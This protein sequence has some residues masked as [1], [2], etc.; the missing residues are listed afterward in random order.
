M[1]VFEKPI[2]EIVKDLL[3]F[4]RICKKEIKLWQEAQ[5]DNE[6]MLSFYQGF[7]YK[8]PKEK[9]CNMHEIIERAVKE[10]RKVPSYLICG[11]NDLH[12]LKNKSII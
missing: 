7:S 4:R 6:K 3:K 2:P 10:G 1:T 11:C 5:I 9:K 12:K 8:K